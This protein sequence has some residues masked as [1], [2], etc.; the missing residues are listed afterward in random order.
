MD[1]FLIFL[2]SLKIAELYK[3]IELFF[4]YVIKILSYKLVNR[5]V[6]SILEPINKHMCINYSL[7]M[8]KSGMWLVPNSASYNLYKIG[9]IV[10]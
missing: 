7:I 1:D 2:N 8:R 6:F 4:G 10:R 3:V 9:S 5:S